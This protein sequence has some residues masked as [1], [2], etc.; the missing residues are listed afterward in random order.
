MTQVP[1]RLPHLRHGRT[2]T[3]CARCTSSPS[4]R[5]RAVGSMLMSQWH[6]VRDGQLA[7]SLLVFDTP[8]ARR[9]GT[10]TAPPRAIGQ[11]VEYRRPRTNTG[12]DEDRDEK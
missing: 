12:C 5:R 9:S 8:W 2:T 7:S 11:Q 6:T 4:R 10:S 1:P 3:R